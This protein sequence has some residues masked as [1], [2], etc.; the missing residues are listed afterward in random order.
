MKLYQE[1]GVSPW[2][3]CLPTLIQFPIIIGLYQAMIQTIASAPLD[4]VNLLRHIYPGLM[5]VSA[6][7]PL[8]T[9]FLW[10]DVGQPER[11]NI[12][13]L[14]VPILAIIVMITTYL[15]QVLITPP[16]TSGNDQ[17]A[18]MNKMMTIYMPLLMGWLALTLASGLAIYFVTTNL[19]GIAQYAVSGRV[20]WDR[21]NPFRKK[22]PAP[23]KK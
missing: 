23:K 19:F 2:S 4:M 8:N 5:K 15:Q 11:L 6:L 9:Q 14:G 20:Y 21:L 3:S 17:G 10:M 12:L 18:M 16:Q 1:A 22:T 7:I 13:G